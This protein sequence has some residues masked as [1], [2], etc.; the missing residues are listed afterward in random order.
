M[1]EQTHTGSGD[2]VAG[3]QQNI[4]RQVNQPVGG[5]YNERPTIININREGEISHNLTP[6]PFIPEIFE[7]REDDL[8][9]VRQRLL[10]DTNLLLLVNGEGG[11]GK[12]SLAA[13]YW[14]RYAA[15]YR[16]AAWLLTIAAA[17]DLADAGLAPGREI[18][19]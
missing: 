2:N 10:A 5:V 17:G 6:P 15:D 18:R 9:A 8:Q 1:A 14:Q 12:T 3:D 16:H 4:G 11:I 19:R 13:K 7:G